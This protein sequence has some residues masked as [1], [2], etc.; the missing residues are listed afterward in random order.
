MKSLAIIGILILLSPTAIFGQ[1]WTHLIIE[2]EMDFSQGNSDVITKITV[3]VD[4]YLQ[5]DGN[6][7]LIVEGL[8]GSN[9]MK[10]Y[11]ESYEI[12]WLDDPQ[13]HVFE[14]NYPFTPNEV[15]QI[16]AING[17][18]SDTIE[19]IPSSFTE[20]ESESQEP[21]KKT[22]NEQTSEKSSGTTE[23]LT[24]DLT[25]QK[26][27]SIQETSEDYDFVQSMIEENEFLRQEIEKKNAVIMEQLKVIQDLASQVSNTIFNESAGKLYFIADTS[28]ESNLVQSII[29]ENELLRQEIEKKDA[30]IMEQLK[31]IQ[32]LASMLRNVIFNPTLNYFST[33]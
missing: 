3:T 14:L 21:E 22:T 20:N 11:E 12:P 28:E 17:E 6:V 9:D 18:E 2:P 1:Q 24:L 30:V 31:V 19:W 8:F 27:I 25:Q 32:D 26:T 23:V 10:T 5:D 15:Y 13:I 33:I 29:E 7:K 4:G 16:T